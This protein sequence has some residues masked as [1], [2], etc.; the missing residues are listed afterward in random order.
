MSS[1]HR[2]D[3]SVDYNDPEL[4]EAL[5]EISDVERSRKLRTAVIAVVALV[6]VGAVLWW[7]VERTDDLFRPNIDV[8]E[9]QQE[10]IADT[11]D[12]VCRGLIIG[13]EE[14]EDEFAELEFDFEDYI[15]ADDPERVEELGDKATSLRNRFAEMS[16]DIDDAVFRKEDISGH[17]PVPEQVEQWFE[18]MDNEFRILEEMADRRLRILADEEVE[19]RGGMW[20]DPRNLRDTVLMTIDENFQEFRTWV[21]RG[22]HPCGPPPEGVEP[23]EPDDPSQIEGVSPEPDADDTQLRDVQVQ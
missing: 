8:E 7:M 19:E 2:D 4:Q 20:D 15:W 12:P 17:P 11:G 6:T 9:G 18:N 22:G 13:V 10:L 23:W 14:L 3:D 1:Q 5:G 16:Q 21:V